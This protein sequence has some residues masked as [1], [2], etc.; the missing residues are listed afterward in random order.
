MPSNAL[1][2]TRY[3]PA[4]AVGSTVIVPEADSVAQA[5]NAEV[6]Y[7]IATRS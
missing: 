6:E 5:G 7:V 4:G 2:V 1:I 3:D